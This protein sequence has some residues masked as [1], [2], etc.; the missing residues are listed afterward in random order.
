MFMAQQQHMCVS[1]RIDGFC[2]LCPVCFDNSL[3]ICV[4]PTCSIQCCQLVH[5]R[6]CHVFHTCLCDNACKIS[7]AIFRKNKALLRITSLLSTPIQPTWLHRGVDMIQT[8]K[9]TNKNML[10]PFQRRTFQIWHLICKRLMSNYETNGEIFPRNL[11]LPRLTV[12]VLHVSC[13]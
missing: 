5:Q 11:Q 13:L 12:T 6:P 10:L 4:S 2:Q 9:Q 7:Q 3:A 8:N 1:G